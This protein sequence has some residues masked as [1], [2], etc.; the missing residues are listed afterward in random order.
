MR[1]PIQKLSW[2]TIGFALFMV[3][4]E[5]SVYIA[6]DMIQPAMPHVVAEFSANPVWI[7]SALTAFMLG[8]GLLTW[9]LGPYSDRHGRRPVLLFG[10]A[11]FT[12]ACVASWWVNS[13]EA[14]MVLRVVQGMGMCY[15]GA[16]GYAAIQEAYAEKPAIQV[17]A[18][19]AN[20]SLLAPLL[21]PLLG[22]WL[23]EWASWHWIFIA[24][25]VVS[26]VAGVGLWRF[27]PETVQLPHVAKAQE[28][29]F[30]LHTARGYWSVLRQGAFVRAALTPTFLI[31]PIIAWIGVGPMILMN[32]YHLS[33]LQFA[34]WQVPVFSAM[35]LGNWVLAYVT[36]KWPLP[37]TLHIGQGATVLGLFIC[38]IMLMLDMTYP[39]LI[40]MMTLLGL[41]DGLSMSVYYRFAM[42]SI[43]AGKGLIAAA[44]NTIFTV[45]LSLGIEAY[46]WVY[47]HLGLWGFWGISAMSIAI[48]LWLAQTSVQTAMAQRE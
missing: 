18:L 31:V 17:M 46:K 15:I 44:F 6:N 21:G 24:I 37:R 30:L 45:V 27:M 36:G 38:A 11:C 25:A 32:D 22:A 47:V 29:H 20:V 7:P 4:F 14:F 19:M 12:L 28:A 9:F 1:H 16:V 23:I 33:S 26:M 8:G 5:F 43:D 40:V 34:Y 39:A 35:V 2:H 3:L 41:A 42:T 10:V 48:F 13:I